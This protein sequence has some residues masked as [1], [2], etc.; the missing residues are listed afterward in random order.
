MQTVQNWI[1][2]IVFALSLSACGK[3]GSNSAGSETSVAGADAGDVNDVDQELADVDLDAADIAGTFDLTVALARLNLSPEAAKPIT[4][5]PDVAPMP[6]EECNTVFERLAGRLKLLEA[7]LDHFFQ[8][9]KAL[10]ERVKKILRDRV[11]FHMKALWERLENLEQRLRNLID[12][13]QVSA[14]DTKFN[15]E[16]I[17]RLVSIIED[18]QLKIERFV[19]SI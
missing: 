10:P 13:V 18:I 17:K 8:R 11:I 19:N 15:G 6:P 2:L 4:V 3:A 1:L 7:R 16:I 14:A 12:R 9:Y 5:R